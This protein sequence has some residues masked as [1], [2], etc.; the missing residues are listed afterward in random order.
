MRQQLNEAAG[1]HGISYAIS[2]IDIF[3]KPNDKRHKQTTWRINL[4]HPDRTLTT[5]EVNKL[6]GIIAD[7]AKKKLK[8]ERIA[9]YMASEQRTIEK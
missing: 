3:Q 2:T 4:W 9:L 7:S 1:Q 5:E 6:L 8:A